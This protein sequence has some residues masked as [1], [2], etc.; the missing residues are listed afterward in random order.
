MKP[1]HAEGHEFEPLAAATPFFYFDNYWFAW[2]F[3]KNGDPMPYLVNHRYVTCLKL[4]EPT[5]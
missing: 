2:A 5:A 3:Y 4:P 1:R